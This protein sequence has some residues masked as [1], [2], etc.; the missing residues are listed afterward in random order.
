MSGSLFFLRFEGVDE[1]A[2][3]FAFHLRRNCIHVD[4]F[5]GQKLAG[6]VFLSELMVS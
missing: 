3:E 2:H 4:P 6:I 5:S 1:G